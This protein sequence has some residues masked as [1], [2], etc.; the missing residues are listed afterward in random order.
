MSKQKK[1]ESP[2]KSFL[3][4]ITKQKS[5]HTSPDRDS[6]L[7]FQQSMRLSFP[8]LRSRSESDGHQAR[9]RMPLKTTKIFTTTRNLPQMHQNCTKDKQTSYNIIV[10]I[11]IISRPATMWGAA[12]VMVRVD[13]P[14]HVNIYNLSEIDVWL[15]GNSNRNLDFL[16]PNL[17]SD[18]RSEVRFR[19]YRCFWVVLQ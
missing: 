13:C 14:S 5:L 4:Q 18:S 7:G 3:W 10:V 16:I 1:R 6:V 11:T 2:N 8:Q 19:H 17:P 15:L 12:G 9:D